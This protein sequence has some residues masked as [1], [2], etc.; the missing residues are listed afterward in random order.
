VA[1]QI[2]FVIRTSGGP[3]ASKVFADIAKSL[4]ALNT[5]LRSSAKI[6]KASVVEQIASTGKLNLALDAG[7]TQRITNVFKAAK[8]EREIRLD[9][10]KF[11]DSQARKDQAREDRINRE[12]RRSRE[13]RAREL[14]QQLER[15]GA[16]TERAARSA[17]RAQVRE[18]RATER[19]EAAVLR[20]R[21]ARL[22]AFFGQLQ[23]L[24][25]ATG[26][27]LTRAV[28][29]IALLGPN[30]RSSLRALSSQF[31]QIGKGAG[32][33]FVG[34]FIT[35]IT[36]G[37]A[38]IP[39]L[40]GRVLGPIVAGVGQIVRAAAQSIVSLG[41]VI[42]ATLSTAV[43][44]LS[45]AFA[46]VLASVVGAVTAAAT[47]ITGVLT[48][49]IG[50]LTQ[51]FGNFLEGISTLLSSTISLIGR[52]LGQVADIATSIVRSVGG[53]VTT[54][55]EATVGRLTSFVG[56]IFG[57]IGGIVSRGLRAIVSPAF[58]LVG[59]LT[60]RATG[61]IRDRV[62]DAFALLDDRSQASVDSVVTSIQ[63]LSAEIGVSANELGDLFFDV[64]SSGFRDI[65]DALEILRRS[66]ELAVAGN[67]EVA[68]AGSALITVLKGLKGAATDA[69]QAAQFLFDVQD[70]GRITIAQLTETFPDLVP[71]ILAAKIPLNEIG[72]LFSVLTLQ[73]QSASETA[74][75]LSQAI[76]QLAAPIP[77]ARRRMRDLNLEIIQLSESDDRAI[78]AIED[79]IFATQR[80][81]EVTQR[82][83]KAF[84]DQRK[85]LAAL[86]SQLSTELQTRGRFVGVIE[87]LRRLRALL[88]KLDADDINVNRAIVSRIRA[89]RAI[90]FLVNNLELVEDQF[91]KINAQP[92]KFVRAISEAQN[93]ISVELRRTV[94]ELGQL[95][96]AL[97][98]LGVAITGGQ[99]FDAIRSVIRR[100]RNFVVE[101][102]P[103]V[104]R[105]RERF[106]FLAQEVLEAFSP[107]RD[108]GFGGLFRRIQQ[109]ITATADV[110]RSSD[111][112]NT[113]AEAFGTGL[114]AVFETFRGA[115]IF[116]LFSRLRSELE[117]FSFG[118]AEQ[119]IRS[120]ADTLDGALDDPTENAITLLDKL[121]ERAS[122]ELRAL[123]RVDTSR[124]EDAR[125]ILAEF[126]RQANVLLGSIGREPITL[127]IA[128]LRGLEQADQA[129]AQ[130]ARLIRAQ[131]TVATNEIN[132]SNIDQ[133]LTDLVGEALD[134]I[135]RLSADFDASLEADSAFD[136][137]NESVDATVDNAR[138]KFTGLEQQVNRVL[139]AIELDPIGIKIEDLDA[140]RRL[141]RLFRE[142]KSEL[143]QRRLTLR[144]VVEGD[145]EIDRLATTTASLQDRDILIRAQSQDA[146]SA[147][148]DFRDAIDNIEPPDE[149]TL[150]AEVQTAI[151]S[152]ARVNTEIEAVG[153]VRARVGIDADI[154]DAI[155]QL[156]RVGAVIRQLP[157]EV[158]IPLEVFLGDS[159]EKLRAL[160]TTLATIR[161]QPPLTVI[162]TAETER[163]LDGI[164]GAFR[165]AEADARV[166]TDRIRAEVETLAE[167]VTASIEVQVV[168][169][170]RARTVIDSLVEQ[171]ERLGLQAPRFE[172]GEIIEDSVFDRVERRLNIVKRILQEDVVEAGRFAQASIEDIVGVDTTVGVDVD[173]RRLVRAQ[174][175]TQFF[176]DQ[177]ELRAAQLVGEINRQLSFIGAEPITIDLS[178][179][180]QAVDDV[181]RQRLSIDLSE[182]DA[183]RERFREG[184]E[185]G[186]IRADTLQAAFDLVEDLERS[187][188]ASFEATRERSSRLVDLEN[189]REFASEI[190]GTVSA[191]SARFVDI[192][193]R[194]IADA[195][196]LGEISPDSI[197]ALTTL[198]API[199]SDLE[200]Q[201]AK[202]LAREEDFVAAGIDVRAVIKGIRADVDILG[203]RGTTG[204]KKLVDELSR[205]ERFSP[206][207]LER[208]NEAVLQLQTSFQASGADLT[209]L[210]E[211]FFDTLNE[212]SGGA[213]G[214]EEPALRAQDVLGNLAA[215]STQTFGVLARGA[216]SAFDS[217]RESTE[218]LGRVGVTAI[219]E[220]G[221]AVSGV[222]SGL[223]EAAEGATEAAD[224]TS[225]VFSGLGRDVQRFIN[226]ARGEFETLS[227][228]IAGTA[229]ASQS[230][231]V[232]L[233]NVVKTRIELFVLR[234][235]QDFEGFLDALGPTFVRLLNQSVDVINGIVNGVSRAVR[236][237]TE[238]FV[239]F[240][241]F[242]GNISIV[243]IVATPFKLA[244]EG[245]INLAGGVFNAI[246]RI[247]TGRAVDAD[248]LLSS[249]FAKIEERAA[250][251]GRTLGDKLIGGLV[252]FTDE[253][254][255]AALSFQARL[256]EEV[257]NLQFR[258]DADA[259]DANNAVDRFLFNFGEREREFRDR[260]LELEVEIALAETAVRDLEEEFRQITGGRPPTFPAKIKLQNLKDELAAARGNLER[261][262]LVE[263]PITP[264]AI[265]V[266][267]KTREILTDIRERQAEI[268]ELQEKA[269]QESGKE[270]KTTEE[271]ITAKEEEL[272][273]A[274]ANLDIVKRI[275]EE[276]GSE[277]GKRTAINRE[278]AAA[279][280]AEKDLLRAI[281]RNLQ[282]IVGDELRR[283]EL[284]KELTDL[285]AAQRRELNL[286][287]DALEA[288][289]ASELQGLDLTRARA[290]AMEKVVEALRE[291]NVEL[292]EFAAT[293]QRI[294][295]LDTG[296]LRQA[297]AA[298]PVEAASE[299]SAGLSQQTLGA[300]LT[301]QRSAASSLG[302]VQ[303]V[304]DQGTI[305]VTADEAFLSNIDEIFQQIGVARP[306]V[307][308]FVG[309]QQVAQGQ[310][311]IPLDPGVAQALLK[312][313]QEQ[314]AAG[315][316]LKIPAEALLEAARDL[317]QFQEL[318][319]GQFPGRVF[320][321]LEGFLVRAGQVRG[322]S[323]AAAASQQG[324]EF[325]LRQASID[326]IGR[327]LAEG[328]NLNVL[329]RALEIQADIERD[330]LENNERQLE[331]FERNF[332]P[333]AGGTGVGTSTL[334][335]PT[336]AD[337]NEL[338]SQTGV[339]TAF[340]DAKL[341]LQRLDV[342][343]L[344]T[345]EQFNSFTRQGLDEFANALAE[346]IEALEEQR[347][348]TGKLVKSTADAAIKTAESNN[349]FQSLQNTLGTLAALRL[350]PEQFFGRQGEEG[351]DLSIQDLAGLLRRDR[352]LVPD[353]DVR[354]LLRRAERGDEGASTAL[355]LA[356]RQ[357]REQLKEGETA[358]PEEAFA[359]AVKEFR[360][361]VDAL[362]EDRKKPPEK[363]PPPGEGEEDNQKLAD[364][365]KEGTKEGTKEGSKEGTKEASLEEQQGRRDSRG[366]KAFRA[367][368]RLQR[369]TRARLRAE[370]EAARPIE[371][372]RPTT[373]GGRP[374]Q[375][376]KPVAKEGIKIDI[377]GL[378]EDVINALTEAVQSVKEGVE[379][380]IEKV[381]DA[382]KK[383]NDD[384]K[385]FIET[386]GEFA[387]FV[388]EVLLE[389]ADVFGAVE[390]AIVESLIPAHESFAATT[391]T[392]SD[393]VTQAI[394]GHTAI[395][396]D[397]EARIGLN[398]AKIVSLDIRVS[399]LGG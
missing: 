126:V 309:Q 43:A 194:I 181:G 211:N 354:N 15:Q 195:Q 45:G 40:V 143:D 315:E 63:R 142:T 80:R 97:F 353:A 398:E 157:D 252:R 342:Q 81:I 101:L 110:I 39:D 280:N 358:G 381:I 186:E 168:G 273:L 356:V 242:F 227:G 365:V 326:E 293:S 189:L 13:R 130:A 172:L 70:R 5:S 52:G 20:R 57:R 206:E 258:I 188:A 21:Q 75:A 331:I 363:P 335:G 151:D 72:A 221:D 183:A 323:R 320:S 140:L 236:T 76:L 95:A 254:D 305:T 359:A 117:G 47:S 249:P 228:I 124:I 113:I 378:P 201:L 38:R 397:H 11:K 350:T 148:V 18:A 67:A 246:K 131:L 304:L 281:Q 4:T 175:A 26:S 12:T 55:F 56:G 114:D 163:A 235:K 108:L 112:A 233:F 92:D 394:E 100:L 37:L 241:Q 336:A 61:Q 386:F 361:A 297:A 239:A 180:E 162:R 226:I 191:S 9:E 149:I 14:R 98:N 208:L 51:F 213:L 231:L 204:L 274:L 247:F 223:A 351:G 127:E 59:A 229:D 104:D 283:K 71:S 215:Q 141:R 355:E 190:Q 203:T 103:V 392:F 299:G 77:Q 292:K 177:T 174:A 64:V 202:L 248:E 265:G 145:D 352:D 393:T 345:T 25:T 46:P 384:L 136:S 377:K 224:T 122:A 129:V 290:L 343:L 65:S 253:A 33:S 50:G 388:E 255:D 216:G 22:R 153:G 282:S 99:G 53:A 82:G 74:T 79:Q 3:Q 207:E 328:V 34:G 332:G 313:T 300:I 198:L 259:A 271:R 383:I 164:S 288:L 267:R 237:M 173:P 158:R 44:G 370:E 369:D 399:N 340:Q 218:S 284:T 364:A 390:L 109:G 185:I 339:F 27:A 244:F 263:D 269:A 19:E 134:E 270:A 125:P 161:D 346:D 286:G 374:E 165:A 31:D 179:I 256:A 169:A 314:A 391:A 32:T 322:V 49:A 217:F 83:T 187:A 279:I 307:G 205:V 167:P 338:I 10:E 285:T 1:E 251:V 138:R 334:Q 214:L 250:E 376:A 302:L 349:A 87:S 368:S 329:I 220:L 389:V 357:L 324:Q 234:A 316:A 160:R 42:A 294:S 277:Q 176:F 115:P 245:I 144:A 200:T 289:N 150:I 261:F 333:G 171:A 133:V 330:I 375:P 147:A 88:D 312:S 154:R 17:R 68:Q 105:L 156:R 89:N 325:L 139:A 66:S 317:R 120:F 362:I 24:A 196:K 382:Q 119:E 308:G 197:S 106:V 41:S 210:W 327:V 102:T 58:L 132:A 48:G 30:I 225:G 319:G 166:T 291:G 62:I 264:E 60:V 184:F 6:F 78:R 238:R 347:E 321:Q 182:L 212:R 137:L 337:V 257:T 266:I 193:G 178:G 116:G 219:G 372:T 373:L 310:G 396:A 232:Q 306:G 379:E 7:L 243:D 8:A 93:K 311:F 73:G 287:L 111:I 91:E 278:R 170:D 230:V 371:P 348:E 296:A 107:L 159:T 298:P 260:K 275:K 262:L 123:V 69:A 192:L 86:Q 301:Q 367:E 29:S 118:R 385:A 23:S 96:V 135:E 222:A 360:A 155:D 90:T 395:L 344:R 268:L 199:S 380:Q 295:L 272:E 84:E 366:S 94:G 85:T 28:G 146:V 303:Q 276:V 240:L 341:S 121:E 2:S 35:T 128:P 36:S 318:G 152:I 209:T 54:I 387:L 16:Q